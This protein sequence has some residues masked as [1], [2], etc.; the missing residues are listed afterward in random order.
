[1]EQLVLNGVKIVQKNHSVGFKIKIRFLKTM[2]PT[3]FYLAYLWMNSNG[4]TSFCLKI[5]SYWVW[6]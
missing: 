2:A 3:L 5:C 4:E 1:M 6:G